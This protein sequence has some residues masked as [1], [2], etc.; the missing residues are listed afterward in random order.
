MTSWKHILLERFAPYLVILVLGLAL[1]LNTALVTG[2]QTALEF[3]YQSIDEAWPEY[4]D[5][6]DAYGYYDVHGQLLWVDNRE[7]H[8]LITEKHFKA[9]RWRTVCDVVLTE[10]NYSGEFPV[11]G[12]KVTVQLE[13][14]DDFADFDLITGPVYR[15]FHVPGSYLLWNGGLLALEIVLFMLFRKLRGT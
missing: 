14:Y 7:W 13:G 8:L 5:L 15:T 11:Q 2:V 12:G 4:Y 6:L 1:L 9:D 3:P 10:Q